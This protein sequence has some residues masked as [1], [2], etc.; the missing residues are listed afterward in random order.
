MKTFEELFWEK[1]DKRDPDECWN[2]K[3]GKFPA[4]YGAIAIHRKNKG[5][6]RL[7]YEFTYGKIPNGLFVCHKCDNKSCCNPRH[8]FLGTN[9]DNM[10]DMYKKGHGADNSCEKNGKHKLTEKDIIK[11][12]KLRKEKEM[13]CEDI[14]EIFCVSRNTVWRILAGRNWTKLTGIKS[15][16]LVRKKL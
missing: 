11:I 1:V 8:L 9:S 10:N 14:A 2:W 13:Y 4:G 15:H 16:N 5:A 12:I 6:H 3:A 7:A